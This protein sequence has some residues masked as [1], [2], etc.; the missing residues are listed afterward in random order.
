[1]ELSQSDQKGLIAKSSAIIWS[2]KYRFIAPYFESVTG[3]PLQEGL[4]ILV[5]VQVNFSE[6]YGMSLVINDIDPEFSVGVKE[7]E[8]QRTIERLQKEGLMG[9]QKELELPLISDGYCIGRTFEAEYENYRLLQP[10]IKGFSFP[11]LLQNMLC[12]HKEHHNRNNCSR[13]IIYIFVI[14]QSNFLSSLKFSSF[15]F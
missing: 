15:F 2:S 7:L 8:R 10:L 3:S 1:M 12:C 13:D 5:K 4:V 9:L 14:F 11:D 6:L